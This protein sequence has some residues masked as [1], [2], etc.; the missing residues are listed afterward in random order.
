MIFGQNIGNAQCAISRTAG[1]PIAAVCTSIELQT[2]WVL[3]PG[4]SY[5]WT[6]PST[7]TILTPNQQTTWIQ[8]P[9]LGNFDVTI[10]I[11]NGGLDVCTETITL[12]GTRVQA[13]AGPNQPNACESTT[14]AADNPAPGTGQWLPVGAEIYGDPAVHNTIVSN[15]PVGTTTLTWQVTNSGCVTSDN[16][17]ITNNT[18]FAVD[19]GAPDEACVNNS[20]TLAGT[21]PGIG[22]TGLWTYVG[23]SGATIVTPT[24]NTSDVTGM[25]TGVHTFRW[26]VTHTVSGCFDDDDVDITNNTVVAVARDITICGTDVNLDADPLNAGETGLWT[27]GGTA[28]ITAPGN[29]NS[30]VTG[31][32]DGANTF[33]W[34]L[35]KGGC[36]DDIDITVTSSNVGPNAGP[37]QHVCA[38][39][40]TMA[41]T[42]VGTWSLVG[43]SGSAT[44][45]NSS[46]SPVTGLG[47]GATGNTFRWTVTEGACAGS[48]DVIIY[49]DTPST[50]NAGLPQTSCDGT[51]NLSANDPVYG[52]GQWT[53]VP[54]AA[55][56]ADDTQ[57]NTSVS[58]LSSGLNTLTWTITNGACV[59]ASNVAITYDVVPPVTAG[60]NQQG[61]VDN[62]VLNATDPGV[63]GSG[64]WSID[65]GNGTFTD[66]TAHNTTVTAVNRQDNIFRWTVTVGGCSD[67]EVVTIS[68]YSVTANAG[69]DDYTCD[70][71]Y[72][73]NANT[74]ASQ[75]IATPPIVATGTWSA[76]PAV[77]PIAFS[78]VNAFNAD[79]SNLVPDGNTLT[80]TIDNGSCSAS[81]DVIISNDMPTVP[82]AGLDDI[83]CG[84]DFDENGEGYT[85]EYNSLNG[86]IPLKVGETGSW[87]LVAGGA[88][89]V[90][91]TNTPN[92]RVT[93]LDHY[94]QL[95]GPDYW[96]QNPTI[97]TF[98]WTITYN[99]CSLYDE[100]SIV[101]AAPF[102]ANAGVDQTVCYDEA[103]LNAVDH[104]SG[105]QT[106][107]WTE[108]APGNSGAIITRSNEFNA[109]VSNLQLN[110]TTFRWTKSNT[111]TF[112]GTTL[113]CTIYDDVIIDRPFSNTARPNAGPNQI[114]CST[115]AD[116]AAAPE[117]IGF[118]ATDN[119]TGTWDVILGNANF[120]VLNSYS[121]HVTNI[122]YRRNVFRWTV[123]NLTQGCIATDDVDITNALPSNANAGPDQWVC[124]NTALLS[125]DRPT[126]GSGEWSVLGGGGTISNTT[127]QD[128]SCNTYVS[129]MG[130]GENT[131][132]WTMS[133]SY[134][135]PASGDSKT[136]VL[137]DE[138]TV[139]NYEVTANAGIDQTVCIDQADLVANQPAGTT[140]VWDVTGGGGSV[141]DVN[142]N[143]TTVVTLSP[144]INTLRWTLDNGSCTAEDLIQI[145]NN[146]PED[147]AAGGDQTIC[148]DNTT[149]V[150]NN[151]V[152]G[153]GT[154]EWSVRLGGGIIVS[155]LNATTAVTNIPQG[156]NTYRWTITKGN[157]EEFDEVDIYNNSVTALAGNDI[158]DICGTEFRNSTVTLNATPPNTVLGETG[159][160]TVVNSFGTIQTVTAFNS[161]VD[162][163]DRDENIFRWTLSNTRN[164]VTCEDDDLVSVFVYIPTTSIAGADREVCFD[165]TG[166]LALNGNNPVHGTGLW[167]WGGT[168]ALVPTFATPSLNTSTV[169]N[170]GL[171]ETI[172]RWTISVNGCASSDEMTV[173]SNYVLAN[174]GADDDI[175]VTNYALDGNDPLIFGQSS[176]GY[177]S[178][179][180]A[181]V[182]ATGTF[183]DPTLYNTTISGLRTTP[184]P[185]NTLRWRIE[186]GSCFS[187]DDVVITNNAITAD[188]G[189]D[190]YTCD[191]FIPNLD[192]NNVEPLGGSGIWTWANAAVVVAPTS[193]RSRVEN[194]Q[195]GLN[196]FTWNV[197]SGS[198]GC[199]D[200]NTVAVYNEAVTA[201]AGFDVET[202][203]TSAT[204]DA[205]NPTKGSGV[206]TRFAGNPVI[207]ADSQANSTIASGLTSGSYTL[208]WT[209][210]Y[211][212]PNVTCTAF[213]D[214]VLLNSST[215]P[216]FAATPDPETCGEDGQLQ[217][218]LPDYGSGETGKWSFFSASGVFAD[219]TNSNTTVSGMQL[220]DNIFTWTLSK[221][222]SIICTSE[223]NVTITNNEI[224]TVTATSGTGSNISCDGTASLEGNDP[225]TEGATGIWTVNTAAVIAD[226]S[227]YI[228]TAN[229]LADGDNIFTWTLTK[230]GC[231]ASANLTI[232]NSEV[233]TDAGPDE[234]VC[235]SSASFNAVDPAPG[236]GLWTI[237]TAGGG[238][239]IANSSSPT[240]AI[241]GLQPGASV[242]RWTTT[243]NT[244]SDFDF[245]TI[246]NDTVQL[247]DGTTQTVCAFEADLTANP[248]DAGQ[249]GVWT[250][251]G[252][253]P[254]IQSS[255]TNVTHVTNLDYG[256]NAFFWT[257]TSSGGCSTQ[258]QYNIIN[259][260]PTPANAGTDQVLCVNSASVTANNP[261]YGTGVWSNPSGSGDIVDANSTQTLINNLGSGIN[262]FRWTITY[263]GCTDDDDVNITNNSFTVD[264]GIDQDLC[265]DNT[266]L[267]ASNDAGGYWSLIA[268]SG[269]IQNS[270]LNTS[271]VSGLGLGANTFRWT[272]TQGICSASSDVIIS[273]NGVPVPTTIGG[274]EYCQADGVGISG[275][276]PVGNQTG[277]WTTGG[278]GIIAVATDFNT[279]VSN[280][281]N[282]TDNIFRWTLTDKGCSSF[283]ELTITNN[284]VTAVAG[285]PQTL[286]SDN[287]TLGAADP[288]LGTGAW[289]VVSSTGILAN[290]LLFNTAVT[291]LNFGVNTFTWTVTRGICSDSDNVTITNNSPSTATAGPDQD[292]CNQTTTLLGNSPIVGTGVWS[293][294]SGTAIIVQPTQFD[295]QVTVDVGSTT[296][297]TWTITNGIC[298]SEDQVTVNNNSFPVYAGIDRTICI[299][300]HVMEAD[301]PGAGTGAWSILSG[302][303]IISNSAQHDATISSLNLGENIFRWTI[304]S[305]GCSVSDDVK[306]T[307][308][309]VSAS[310]TDH[311][312]CVDNT[313]L[314]GNDPSLL[315]SQG[316]W[317]LTAPVG[318]S[319]TT[320]T[321]FNTTVTNLTPGIN[322]LKWTVF[323]ASC[324]AE[325][326]IQ[327]EY[328]IPTANAG[329]DVPYRCENSIQLNANQPPV[330]GS[331]VWNTVS[332]STIVQPT[333]Y[334]T[335]V[336]NLDIGDN[337]FRWTIS[338]RGCTNFDEVT[339]NNSLPE[340]DDG[341]DQVGCTDNFSMA[342]EDP[343]VSGGTGLWSVTAGS[344]NFADDTRFNTSVIVGLGTN[345]L[346]WTIINNGCSA[347]KNFS[348]TNN[349]TNPQAGADV[350]VCV[351]EVTLAAA[352]ATPDQGVW[353]IVG[354]ATSEVFDNA[355]IYNATVTGLRKGNIT[356]EWTVSNGICSA[357]DFVVVTNNTP[358]ITAG[359]D[360]T[361]CETFVTLSGN[362]P[363]LDGNTGLWTNE[364][365]TGIIMT[366]TLFNSQVTDLAQGANEYKWTVTNG[367]CT[368][369]DNV[370]ITNNLVAVTAG[371]DQSV[372]S[373]T[374]ALQAV[375]PP[376]GATGLWTAVIGSATFDNAT[377][378]NTT[379]R[380]LTSGSNILRWTVTAN[381]CPNSDEIE[382][383]SE[384]PINAAFTEA[385]KAICEN[386]TTMSAN[387]PD[388]AHGETGLWSIVGAGSATIVDPT[389]IVTDVTGLDQGINNFRW[390]IDNNGCTSTDDLAITNNQ[391]FSDAGPD[392]RLCI[393]T[394]TMN[395]GGAG[396]NSG[397]W[398][399]VGSSNAIIA[400]STD[401]QTAISNLDPGINTFKWTVTGTGCSA[402]DEVVLYNDIPTVPDAGSD[403]YICD[404]TAP[405]SANNPDVNR[406]TGVWNREG[407]LGIITDVS[408]FNTTV[409]GLGAGRNTFSWTITLNDCS[410]RDDMDIYNNSVIVNAGVPQ[411][412]CTDEY[413]LGGNDPGA[414][415][416]SWTVIGGAGIFDDTAIHDTWVRSLAKGQN[417][418]RWTINDGTCENYDEVT[419]MN[420]L[421]VTPVVEGDKDVCTDFATIGVNPAPD[422]LNNESGL[423]I[424]TAG[425]G[426]IADATAANTSVSGLTPDGNTFQWTV[427]KSTGGIDCSL[428]DE[429]IITNNAV[430]ASTGSDKAVC[431]TTSTLSANDPGTGIGTWTRL[432]GTG[433]IAQPSDNNTTVSNLSTGEN[434]F[435]W[436]IVRNLCSDFADV[437]ITNNQYI[438]NANPGGANVLC[439]DYS[440]V[441]A[442]IPPAGTSG[443]WSMFAG[444]GT[445][446]DETN[447]TTYVRNL[448]QGQNWIHWTVSKDGCDTYTEFDITNNSVSTEAGGDQIVCTDFTNLNAT[449]APAG[450]SGFWT[451]L[452]GAGIIAN[453]A[454]SAT[455]VSNLSLGSNIFRWRIDANGCFDESTLIVSNNTF[456]VSA[457]NDQIN[458]GTTYTLAG[459]DPSPGY[460]IWTVEGG[461]GVF[462]DQSFNGTLVSDLDNLDNT[463]RW[464]IT[465]NGCT[466]SDI[467]TITNDLFIAVAG[468]DQQVC[469]DQTT[470]SAQPLN[471][472]W[473]AT[474][475]WTVQNGAG[476]FANPTMENTLITGLASGN[477][478]LRWTVTKGLCVSYDEIIVTN[479]YPVISAGT[480]Q[481][482]CDDFITLS[483]TPLTATGVGLWSGGGVNTIIV[484][485]SSSTT[486]VTNLAQGINTF[487]WT[488]TDNGC[489]GTATVQ[490]TSNYFTAVA[491]PNQVV[492]VNNAVMA[493]QLP[494]VT[495][496]G[497][498]SVFSGSGNI[499]NVTNP[500]EP[501]TNLGFGVNTFRWTVSWNSC[502]AY[503]DVNITY[504]AITA[505]AGPQQTICSDITNL[506]AAD[507]FPGTG[508][509]TLISG[510]AVFN[511]V[512]DPNTGITGIQPGSINIFR[513]TVEIGG[514]SE[515]DDV[516]VLNSEFE[517]SAGV[518]KEECESE[519]VMTA[520]NAGA[521]TGTWSVLAGGGNF[522]DNTLNTSA[523]TNMAEGINLFVWRV[524]KNTG[525]INS[526]TVQVTY[527]LPP[528]ALFDMD[529]STGCTPI[530]VEFTNTS[531][532]G[533]VYYWNFGDDFRTDSS[534]TTFTRTYEALHDKDSTYS[535]QL[536]AESAKGCY[537][538]IVQQV[539]TY[540][541][542]IVNFA[543]SPF[544]QVY[545]RATVN[546]ENLSGEGYNNYHWDFDDGNTELHNSM[547]EAFSHI[548][549]TWGKYEIVLSVY[550]SNCS[551]T[552]R[553]EIEILAPQ[554]ESTIQAG[555]RASG[556][557]DLS[558]NFEAY[559]N[560]ADTFYWEFGNV[561]E[562]HVENPPFI[563][564]DPGTYIIRLW[565]G[566]PGTNHDIDTA[567]TPPVRVDTVKVFAMPKA[568]FDVLPDTVMLPDQPIICHNT[569]INGYRYQ[570]NF[571]SVNDSL[572]TEKSPV[573]YYTEAGIYT[574]TLDVWTE[575]GCHHSR[576][577]EYPVVVEPAGTFAF[578]TAFN[579]YSDYELNKIFKPLHRGVREYKLEIYNRWGEKVF[580]SNNPETG[581]DGYIDGKIGAQDVYVWKLSGKYKN[582][583]IFKATGDVTLL[584]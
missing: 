124:T 369:D 69:F 469:S 536:V 364:S 37:D 520:E 391:V 196:S 266:T 383:I 242:F 531:V 558:V 89:F 105:A 548:Y 147:P 310:A 119:V 411:I 25:G 572:S 113:T 211:T 291:N 38:T 361:V 423:W 273:N 566:G 213:D 162:G 579:P 148:V 100:V 452:S 158:D 355:S 131:F 320:P 370:V 166:N 327:V 49:N 339:I 234:T 303:G 83:F 500:T 540:R 360:R 258:K 125:A 13:E 292:I 6:T 173:T 429:I 545:P 198:G 336:N 12:T 400:N 16:V 285:G 104:G 509:W 399:I 456:S 321:L 274:G 343:S 519:S 7:A 42:G 415:T 289:T 440:E 344:A 299:D 27:T 226:N 267:D 325:Q 26:T 82:D 77:P 14:L 137:T 381:G 186:K 271:T 313:V 35:T 347:S 551:D 464:T 527:N 115:E 375:A 337:V 156:Q 311:M 192:G 409:T 262:V 525:C 117:D 512:H 441:I 97:N 129:N 18:P 66:I 22:E 450:G 491:G 230:G 41:A 580:E 281:S 476:I 135:D 63:T 342:A 54:P 151:P 485:P 23:G 556:C 1:D 146:N 515:Y 39:T 284:S 390:T 174:A 404:N 257:V 413:Q 557:E 385:D 513:W 240:S 349:L 466:F 86:N 410:L 19:A 555:L 490:I 533:N 453:T 40:A 506:A 177:A 209:V 382:I 530:D 314:D 478:R 94:S 356:F 300:S 341:G 272:A 561:G 537:D 477:N 394:A 282:V 253:N 326:T 397:A 553:Q 458:C 567:N 170:L 293:T 252:I 455:S 332:G 433:I 304:S 109:Y 227:A 378:H 488:V 76:L 195:S 574:V 312:E 169:T 554:P 398:T 133:N 268:G 420:N 276:P 412:I 511:D 168:G 405:L 259:N 322:F 78:D 17:D 526:D 448:G 543:A 34:E 387:A 422:Y 275:T 161:V 90:D 494:D 376:V 200:D 96:N 206:W 67:S 180:W 457:G 205:T 443:M 479:N 81:D 581:W 261:I 507:P 357:P 495:A 451:R 331:G 52:T 473:G 153:M 430:T 130:Y 436:T 492:T 318:A 208:R 481:T 56:F 143:I 544:V 2:A 582:G 72:T 462:A 278:A 102:A 468:D 32:S 98:R 379:A 362:N 114:V 346:T 565:A 128:F 108:H 287:T 523:V 202:C 264:A 503:D 236:T 431:G 564:E 256:N 111:L 122:A 229:N 138:I 417:T 121:T 401:N 324:S 425:G 154:G 245:V 437:T 384:L 472:I 182:N 306:L 20:I 203:N 297:F 127:C 218:T 221:G 118:P 197:T 43:G 465:K 167:S 419:I 482:T 15:L 223:A 24:L 112:G 250:A 406:G 201:N 244:C 116:M 59:S 228:T 178:G 584:R 532:N 217:G 134:T 212:N 563:F 334:N 386:Y 317:T 189:A 426:T 181:L 350:S 68:N 333:L 58:G 396:S 432:S 53:A 358:P 434:I 335:F 309:T 345:I 296:V 126:R 570:W 340:N 427:T 329:A 330:T 85:E 353:S 562:A 214:M 438:A 408:Q 483:A 315:N 44:I 51:A 99:N 493:A 449:A 510:S 573:H 549:S 470:V 474:G 231:N 215:Q 351:D 459:D 359:A 64:V 535:V 199:T 62:Y 88:T 559:V 171:N 505:D 428:S 393:T 328:Y 463:F 560:Y 207:F 184:V 392:Q 577:R 193:Y 388:Y 418:L 307:N 365:G 367:I 71:T 569:S 149:L 233:I 106:H 9:P 165:E 487:A 183:A 79:V 368:A 144:N 5:Q 210:T 224:T 28:T 55:S 583:T 152:A 185:D 578:P 294:L 395:A 547:V 73:L 518:D 279:T 421:P 377:V 95:T 407:G 260:S 33:N 508:T 179:Q 280:L 10:T 107:F 517:I 243:R 204:I 241:S 486:L 255:N 461:N 139:W 414:A 269:I 60:V 522:A 416:G 132:R 348:I 103:N 516:T 447:N 176:Y 514:Y 246:T 576:E 3:G 145:I 80:W 91:P 338:D 219:D 484:D 471:P 496:S 159:V 442:D 48:D 290:S 301:D 92:A 8:D 366:P 220:G 238:T 524:V 30:F 160:W 136:C 46:V 373:D 403:Q 47:Q 123:N 75:N 140:G 286:C 480:N 222:N 163:M 475:L 460:G 11:V 190:I 568:Y 254:I 93:N 504:N 380:T 542:P 534:L 251:A 439:V 298:V 36:T 305:G 283:D 270:L 87:T 110:Q 157:C 249:T 363:A 191:N 277:L 446:D 502:T 499:A 61:C 372:C 316:I 84:I 571:G 29:P 4:D 539:T 402:E 288:A 538:T 444:I 489:E 354:G 265:V 141:I 424:R 194:L 529:Q 142:S 232:N 374:Y 150:A 248:L 21:A 528:T 352:D 302:S 445:F 247:A 575:H 216:A 172:L 70:A 188:A 435:R 65:Q 263:N 498:W 541:I 175:C 74:A 164:M 101:N 371:I 389:S 45:P 454:S 497:V 319:I 57:F 546:I 323:N 155:S 237:V 31:L 295:T 225:A 521:G 308:R 501:V 235:G 550:S 239:I 552:V 120:D 187:E 467:V 50:S